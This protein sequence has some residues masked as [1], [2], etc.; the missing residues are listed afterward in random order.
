VTR[1]VE[2]LAIVF[3]VTLPFGFYRAHTR[4]LSWRWFLAIHLPVPLVFL[5]RYE[6]HL[7]YAFI[8]FTCMAFAAAQLLGGMAGR[9]WLRRHPRE[10]AAKGDEPPPP[11]PPS[12][13][14]VPS[15]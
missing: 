5:A 14:G 10:A 9:R 1:I 12:G 3:V 4:K 7:S 6:S 2:V 15:T 11:A 8:P 13:P